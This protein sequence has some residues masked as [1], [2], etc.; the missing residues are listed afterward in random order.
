MLTCWFGAAHGYS[1][2][3]HKAE[4]AVSKRLSVGLLALV[5]F[6]YR[7]CR[8]LTVRT[9]MDFWTEKKYYFQTIT[10]GNKQI[11]F[12]IVCLCF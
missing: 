12:A 4:K 1:T 7:I 5:N 10:L 9:E 8:N 11:I 6:Y 2:E 3:E